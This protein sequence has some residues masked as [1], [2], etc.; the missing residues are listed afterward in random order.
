MRSISN[1][2]WI[3]IRKEIS[4]VKWAENTLRIYLIKYAYFSHMF[5]SVMS[6]PSAILSWLHHLLEFYVMNI[7][8][9]FRDASL[10]PGHCLIVL[11]PGNDMGKISWYLT[12][13]IHKESNDWGL[14]D[15]L[16]V[17]LGVK[18]LFSFILEK[19]I[20]QFQNHIDTYVEG[21]TLT[22]WGRDKMAA[23]F[24]TTFWNAFS[25]MKMYE[26]QLKFHWSLFLR[27][28]LTI[29]QHWFR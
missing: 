4:L 27:V 16:V 12:T 28:Q 10:A 6:I 17:W 15:Y 22:H 21:A 14:F 13:V 23:I 2:H 11:A 5:Y 25:W 19:S 29:F 20:Q 3:W 9:F 7:P 26:F 1:F 18:V 24:Q 8:M